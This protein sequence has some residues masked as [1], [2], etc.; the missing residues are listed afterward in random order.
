MAFL[1]VLAETK[2]KASPS[3]AE[4]VHNRIG[5][6]RRKWEPVSAFG[7]AARYVLYVLVPIAE[8]MADF[9]PEHSNGIKFQVALEVF[10][11]YAKCP[12]HRTWEKTLSYR[13]TPNVFIANY[14]CAG[15]HSF[16]EGYS[17]L[18]A[19]S[20]PIVGSL[21]KILSYSLERVATG[22]ATLI[23]RVSEV[24]LRR[25]YKVVEATTD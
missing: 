12:I 15:R 6:V 9:V 3:S 13:T 7:E 1:V 14:E 19:C 5:R 11:E 4:I 16:C 8:N 25:S 20:D 21:T 22:E 23:E 17:T 24:T 18:R 2:I 10:W